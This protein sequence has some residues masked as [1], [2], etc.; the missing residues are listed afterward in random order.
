MLGGGS[1][2][3]TPPGVCGPPKQRGEGRARTAPGASQRILI[4]ENPH[5]L[6]GVLAED[7]LDDHDGLLHHVVDLGLDEVQQG[8]HTAL[9]RLL[10]RAEKHNLKG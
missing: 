9:C 4:P 10:E 3:F 8:A 7:V 1:R 2:G 5:A 6:V